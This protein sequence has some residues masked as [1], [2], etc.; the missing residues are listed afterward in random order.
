MCAET[1]AST[2]DIS[3]SLNVFISGWGDYCTKPLDLLNWVS[4]LI[5]SAITFKLI[6]LQNNNNSF[7]KNLGSL[8]LLTTFNWVHLYRYSLYQQAKIPFS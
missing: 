5:G 7:L 3:S 4:C 1:A 8:L 2:G 6:Y